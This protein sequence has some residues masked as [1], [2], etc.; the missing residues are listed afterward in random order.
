MCVASVVFNPFNGLILTSTSTERA[1]EFQIIEEIIGNLIKCVFNH[2]NARGVV[3]VLQDDKQV[4]TSVPPLAVSCLHPAGP[5]RRLFVR[6]RGRAATIPLGPIHTRDYRRLR[7]SPASPRCTCHT[8]TTKMALSVLDAGRF[9]F[10][11]G[12]P[13]VHA[14]RPYFLINATMIPTVGSP[15]NASTNTV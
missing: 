12:R 1:Y 3:H 8:R 15:V 14:E 7:S 10:M 5:G 2:Q 13:T 9:C 4:T 11:Y 6:R